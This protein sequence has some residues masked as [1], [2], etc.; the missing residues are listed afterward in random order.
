MKSLFCWQSLND[1]YD[2]ESAFFRKGKL[3]DRT[4]WS[5]LLVQ[6]E[7]S[8]VSPCLPQQQWLTDQVLM[9]EQLGKLK[10]M[11]YMKWTTIRRRVWL[12]FRWSVVIIIFARFELAVVAEAYTWKQ[13]SSTFILYH[14]FSRNSSVGFLQRSFF[15]FNTK[16]SSSTLKTPLAPCD[17]LL[18][19][20]SLSWP[21]FLLSPS[22]YSR[23]RDKIHYFLWKEQPWRVSDKTNNEIKITIQVPHV[24]IK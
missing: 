16:G 17:C 20:F 18:A 5:P 4:K 14:T 13:L 6:E 7:T 9:P 3:S 19:P 11:R 2:E 8:R 12:E 21:S 23:E 15:S 22:T 1:V 24:N 10:V